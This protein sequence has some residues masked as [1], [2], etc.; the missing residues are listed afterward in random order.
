M[1]PKYVEKEK[2]Q[3]VAKSSK[4][5]RFQIDDLIKKIHVDPGASL[6]KRVN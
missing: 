3:I 5:F 1:D 6:R 4:I 2:Q